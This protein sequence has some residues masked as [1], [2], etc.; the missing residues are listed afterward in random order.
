MRLLKSGAPSFHQ[1]GP[2]SPSPRLAA[3]TAARALRSAPASDCRP[4]PAA[5]LAPAPDCSCATGG[6]PPRSSG[7]PACPGIFAGLRRLFS[8]QH[9]TRF[10]LR[11]IARKWRQIAGTGARRHGRIKTSAPIFT[12]LRE[13]IVTVVSIVFTWQHIEQRRFH[14]RMRKDRHEKQSRWLV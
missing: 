12:C 13:C 1:T 6:R 11:H 10:D 3:S 2:R 5:G 14:H 7:R 4:A 9:R 8:S